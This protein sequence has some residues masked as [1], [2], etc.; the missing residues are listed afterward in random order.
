PDKCRIIPFGIELDP[1]A[2]TPDVRAEAAELRARFGE[3]PLLLF[4]GRL[5]HYK[6]LHVLLDAMHQVDAHLLVIGSGPMGEEW[7]RKAATEGLGHKVTFWGERPDRDKLAA[8]H[9]ADLF[10][11]PSNNRAEAF[12]LVLVEALAFRLTVCSAVLVSGNSWSNLHAHTA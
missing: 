3:R 5:R 10:V 12:G 9:A 8:Y 1:L 2:G 7:Q 6:G 11:L 4:V